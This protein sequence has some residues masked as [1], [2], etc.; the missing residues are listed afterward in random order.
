MVVISEWA[1]RGKLLCCLFWAGGSPREDGSFIWMITRPTGVQVCFNGFELVQKWLKRSF[2]FGWLFPLTFVLQFMRKRI[3]AEVRNTR[4]TVGD[5][6]KVMNQVIQ[7]CCLW[8]VMM[9]AQGLCQFCTPCR[10]KILWHV[11]LVKLGQPVRKK[12]KRP[13]LMTGSIYTYCT[14]SSWVELES[15]EKHRRQIQ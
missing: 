7:L 6:D 8:L 9:K 3:M 4:V 11:K 15:H 14:Y 2:R 5:Q 10:N 13:S 12:I 1:S